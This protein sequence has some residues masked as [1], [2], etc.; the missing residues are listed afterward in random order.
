MH[1][2]QPEDDFYSAER[3][4]RTWRIV[5]AHVLVVATFFTATFFWGNFQ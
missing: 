3:R 2:N 4:K 5:I 1:E